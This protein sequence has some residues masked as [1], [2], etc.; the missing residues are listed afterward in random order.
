MAFVQEAEEEHHHHHHH[1][2]KRVRPK[3]AQAQG[4]A[5]LQ[6]KKNKSSRSSRS[7]TP[8]TAQEEEEKFLPEP[9]VSTPSLPH[10]QESRASTA[11]SVSSHVES[12]LPP[13]E[14]QD[15]GMNEQ[16]AAAASHGDKL[17]RKLS[18]LSSRHTS[19]TNHSL[20]KSQASSR[21]QSS[22]TTGTASRLSCSTCVSCGPSSCSVCAREGAQTHSTC[23]TKSA[24]ISAAEKKA[25]QVRKDLFKYV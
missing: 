22:R 15:V 25:N 6:K 12:I 24:I 13:V 21:A 14:D 5:D 17:S 8:Q 7:V 1:H 18:S 4:A 11:K 9:Q 20:A 16:E 19:L 2:H 3:S 23:S 10:S